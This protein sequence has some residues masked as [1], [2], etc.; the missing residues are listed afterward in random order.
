MTKNVAATTHTFQD[1]GAGVF[2]TGAPVVVGDRPYI[3]LTGNNPHLAD[4]RCCFRL[5]IRRG[6]NRWSVCC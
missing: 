5:C 3:L 4:S 2:R 1:H 6:Y